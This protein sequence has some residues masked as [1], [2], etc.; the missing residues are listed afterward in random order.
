LEKASGKKAFDA[1]AADGF[2]T[3]FSEKYVLQCS[4]RR[5]IIAAVEEM[6]PHF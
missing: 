2:R 3:Y 5:V 1:A 6:Y 4:P